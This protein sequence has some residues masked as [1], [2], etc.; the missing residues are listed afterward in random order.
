MGAASGASFVSLGLAGALA[1]FLQFVL[2][3]TS[4]AQVMLMYV[5]AV[6][7]VLLVGLFPIAAAAAFTARGKELLDRY[8]KWTLAWLLWKPVAATIYAAG[9]LMIETGAPSR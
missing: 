1:T 3:L 4:I 5:R 9:L 2:M 6:L 8:L 7:L